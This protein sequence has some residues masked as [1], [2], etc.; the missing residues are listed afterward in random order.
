LFIAEI[1]DPEFNLLGWVVVHSLGSDGSCGG[2]RLYP[3]VGRHEVE[4]LARAMTC[5]YSFFGKTMG[6]AK[7][8]LRIGF[9]TS[10]AERSVMLTK[11]GEHIG[12]LIRSGLYYPWTDM[13]CNSE[14][15][16]YI[17]QGAGLKSV[18][19]SE[20]AYFTALSTFAGLLAVGERY[21]IPP[22]Q[23]RVTV[24]GMGNVGKWL[25]LEI[26]RLGGRLIGA[27]TRIGAVKNEN[28]I[29]VKHMISL[30]KKTGD[31]W[32]QEKGD[33]EAISARDLF[34]L[35]MNLHV[36][37]SRVNSITA[38]VADQ[39]HCK[40]VVPA[41]N[42]PCTPEGQVRLRQRDIKL[43]PDFVLNGGGIIGSSLRDLGHELNEIR[44]FFYTDFHEMIR[45]LLQEADQRQITPVELAQ[46][47]ADK[48]YQRLW[49]SGQ[50]TPTYAKK[51]YRALVWRGLIPKRM[52]LSE[53]K[54]ALNQMVSD[55]F[56]SH[57]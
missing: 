25:A 6:G 48:L 27:S 54:R 41:A 12:P 45:R 4:L 46:F 26:G 33:W 11:F 36:P 31:F 39:L 47:E 50:K 37:C 14:D 5:K 1:E 55:R 32:V 18:R 10:P 57:G 24:E 35:P 16:A 51:I 29:N 38:E 2:V 42:V 43:L 44:T 30:I 20:S 19:K 9:D 53:R 3:D 28:G 13:N 52:L 22:E 7:A 21:K 56:K 17:Y 40:F 23:W 8:G 15:L 34:S 49:A